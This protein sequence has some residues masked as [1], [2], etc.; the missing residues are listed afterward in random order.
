MF[1]I[2]NILPIYDQNV[3]KISHFSASNLNIYHSQNFEPPLVNLKQK[4][5]GTRCRADY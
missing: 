2:E 1:Q 5:S 3:N 4:I